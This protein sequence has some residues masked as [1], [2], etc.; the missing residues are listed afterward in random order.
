MP[1]VTRKTHSVALKSLAT[2]ALYRYCSYNENHS[3]PNAFTTDTPI[4]PGFFSSFKQAQSEPQIDRYYI[5]LREPLRSVYSFRGTQSPVE[6][7]GPPWLAV[8]LSSVLEQDIAFPPYMKRIHHPSYTW[9]IMCCVLPAEEE[10]DV[11]GGERSA[12]TRQRHMGLA[13]I[14]FVVAYTRKQ[15]PTFAKALFYCLLFT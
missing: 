9:W 8:V 14:Y 11:R 15:M 10:G 3:L 1:Q 7:K 6:V 5:S 12:V 4:R 13:E 2:T